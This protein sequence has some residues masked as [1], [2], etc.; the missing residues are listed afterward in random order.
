MKAIYS[1]F[2]F[3][4]DMTTSIEVSNHCTLD[5]AIQIASSLFLMASKPVRV[6]DTESS[7]AVASFFNV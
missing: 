1:I 6:I 5:K 7:E 2:I 4:E 3:S